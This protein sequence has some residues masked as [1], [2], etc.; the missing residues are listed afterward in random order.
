MRGSLFALVG[1][2]FLFMAPAMATAQVR[3]PWTTDPVVSPLVTYRL[4][5]S[6]LVEGSVS[7]HV[8]LPPTYASEPM[9]RFP[10]V[11]W[12]HGSDSTTEGVAAVADAFDR[13]IRAGKMPPVIL[14]FPNG[15]PFGMWCDARSGLQPVESILMHELVPEV[16][17]LFRTIAEPRARLLEGFSMGGYG[18]A[19]L[20]LRFREMFVGF[21][22]LGAGP[23]QLD[24]L[25]DQ[26]GAKPIALRRRI[27]DEV[28]GGSAAYFIAQ[29]PWRFAEARG[30]ALR[31]DPPKIRQIIGTLDGSLQANRDF[32]QRLATLQIAH[33]YVE[34]P[35]VGHTVPGLM[36][37]LGDR[38]WAFYGEAFD[39]LDPQGYA[40]HDYSGNWYA[41]A[42]SGWGLAVQSYGAQ[43][44]VL[45][46][47]YDAGRPE[48]FHLQARWSGPDTLDA[49]ALRRT[50][51][52]AWG[53]PGF[54]TEDQRDTPLGSLRLQFTGRDT[55]RLSGSVNGRSV[56]AD[57]VRLQ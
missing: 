17:R 31:R 36:S 13:A 25:E 14:V 2:F 7:Y 42:N 55:L 15:L 6:V 3:P 27:L 8:Y 54:R 18:A 44:L 34:V 37:A 51:P 19:R 50:N 4:I 52:G 29:S 40:S 20:G 22:M 12:L 49:E 26:P 41:P 43:V 28:Y 33:A 11:Y 10:V 16:D 30:P 38:F 24:L 47:V 56:A 53:T 46:F 35:G 45:G 48:W 23:L 32:T 57:L 9:R 21:S 39:R 5:E 1:A